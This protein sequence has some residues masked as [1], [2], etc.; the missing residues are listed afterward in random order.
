MKQEIKGIDRDGVREVVQGT[1]H[2]VWISGGVTTIEELA[3]LDEIGAVGAVLG[4]ALYTNTMDAEEV[5][6]RFGAIHLPAP[7]DANGSE[8]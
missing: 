1:R 5:G 6:R 4:M 3:F 8:G 2:P 7:R